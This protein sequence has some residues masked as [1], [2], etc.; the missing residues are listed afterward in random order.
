MKIK[1]S[2]QPQDFDMGVEVDKIRNHSA[3][4]G[5]IVAFCGLCRSEGGRLSALEIEHYPGMAEKRIKQIVD[6]ASTRW[7]LEGVTVIHR[8]G[9][10]K[11]GEQIV[12]VVTAS[13]HRREAF[14]AANFIMDFLKTEAPFWKKEHL[15]DGTPQNWVEAKA[16]DEHTKV[17]WQKKSGQSKK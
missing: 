14:D 13:P 15:R 7:S 5:G 10:I 16:T 9:T 3:S 17:R 6:D 4:V 12:L 1:I 11:V 8:F 2:V